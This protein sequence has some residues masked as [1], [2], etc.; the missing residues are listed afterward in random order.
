MRDEV[1]LARS[2]SKNR[3]TNWVAHPDPTVVLLRLLCPFVPSAAPGVVHVQDFGPLENLVVFSDL[4]LR[5]LLLLHHL[6]LR[7]LASRVRARRRA[8]ST[9]APPARRHR[10]PDPHP[11]ERRIEI[12]CT[13]RRR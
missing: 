5:L 1:S 9:P 13:H 6:R 12:T 8:A 4:L 10:P 11:T 3:M 2:G 7:V